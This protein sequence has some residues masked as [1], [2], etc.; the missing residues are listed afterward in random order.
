M[1]SFIHF[2]LFLCLFINAR[3][4]TAGPS[5]QCLSFKKIQKNIKS[6]CTNFII[7]PNNTTYLTCNITEIN[8]ITKNTCLQTYTSVQLTFPNDLIF[9]YIFKNHRKVIYSLFKTSKKNT[10]NITLGVF[11][12]STIDKSY[13]ESI[14]GNASKPYNSLYIYI[15]KRNV[16]QALP[17]ID[18]NLNQFN[19][20][21]F[22][23][24]IPCNNSRGNI[25]YKINKTAII[26]K[27]EICKTPSTTLSTKSTRTEKQN[28]DIST[29]EATQ[30]RT[31]SSI[32]LTTQM[33]II[34]SVF[35]TLNEILPE[36]N[37]ITSTFIMITTSRTDTTS[38]SFS[39]STKPSRKLLL[40]FLLPGLLVFT[41]FTSLIIMHFI[42]K[43]RRKPSDILHE[44]SSDES[45]ALSNDLSDTS[46]TQSVISSSSKSTAYLSPHKPRSASHFNNRMTLEFDKDF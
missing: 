23:L 45:L 41:I 35:P 20:S 9:E 7:I 32:N 14:L 10:F 22:Q 29:L 44:N 3:L 46:N 6:S 18:A 38:S 1:L 30:A 39:S 4:S 15:L 12:R 5:S 17:Y 36:D 16:N 19:I 25:H 28:N 43:N 26:V 8:N 24:Y 31:K 40:L 34:T 11:N 42:L 33:P 37:S 27:D 13:I 21:L 2:Y